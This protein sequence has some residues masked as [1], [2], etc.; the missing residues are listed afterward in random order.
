VITS[1]SFMEWLERI[2]ISFINVMARYGVYDGRYSVPL[3]D[4]VDNTECRFGHDVTHKYLTVWWQ[5]LQ[6]A[7]ALIT[8]RPECPTVRLLLV[9]R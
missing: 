3:D 8:K 7:W 5:N 9:K 6:V 2:C 1:T 4:S